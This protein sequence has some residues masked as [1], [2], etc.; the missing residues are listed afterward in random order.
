MKTIWLAPI[1]L[2]YLICGCAQ[3]GIVAGVNSTNAQGV[4]GFDNKSGDG[5][6]F[7]YSTMG[8]VRNSDNWIV[9]SGLQ[10][11]KRTLN[12]SNGSS[13]G[14]IDFV[15]M[16]IPL[17]YDYRINKNFFLGLGGILSS[18]TGAQCHVNS[19]ACSTNSSKRVTMFGNVEAGLQFSENLELAGYLE[20][21][22]GDF[23]EGGTNA[24]SV[25]IRFKFFFDREISKN[26]L[27]SYFR[28]K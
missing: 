22:L 19:M 20:Q 13:E 27:N 18:N 17:I 5:F 10:V 14:Y 12:F 28:G 16:E 7:G 24:N 23:Y 4:N 8:P 9:K 25:G 11:S 21:S 1:L 3:V 26:M 6:L 2:S 15:S